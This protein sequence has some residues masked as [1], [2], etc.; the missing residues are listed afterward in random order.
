MAKMIGK[1]RLIVELVVRSIIPPFYSFS[2]IE[3]ICRKKLE[4]QPNNS[5]TLWFLANFYVWHKKYSDAKVQLEKL[6]EIRPDARSVKLLLAKVFYMLGQH[7]RV[8]ELLMTPGILTE[9]DEANYFLGDSLLLLN[10]F[11]QAIT[12]LNRYV[13]YHPKDYVPFVRLGYAYYMHGRHEE[14]LTAYKRAESL[15][16]SSEE[17]KNSIDLCIKKLSETT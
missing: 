8:E 10:K 11:D 17:I 2:L 13:R 14:A 5:D 16:P 12:Y 4:A 3:R 1:W 15:K 9:K 6:T 7:Y